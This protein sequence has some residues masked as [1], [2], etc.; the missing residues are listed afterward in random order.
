MSTGNREKYINLEFT[1]EQD[2]HSQIK[3]NLGHSHT[4][5]SWT[6]LSLLV[7][8]PKYFWRENLSWKVKTANSN[9]NPYGNRIHQYRQ[10]QTPIE[11]L[12][13]FSTEIKGKIHNMFMNLSVHL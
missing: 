5:K 1:T 3:E 9:S 4:N 12:L 11:L 10:I 8:P 7:L 13:L 6:N 2:S